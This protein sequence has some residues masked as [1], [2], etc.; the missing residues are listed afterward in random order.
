M[1]KEDVDDVERR[2]LT[3]L[4]LLQKRPTVEQVNL[5]DVAKDDTALASQRL[6]DVITTHFRYVVVDD[7]AQ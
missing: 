2:L 1:S 5:L 4:E 7:E 3:S 6:D